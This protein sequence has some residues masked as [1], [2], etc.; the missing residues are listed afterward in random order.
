MY[1]KVRGEAVMSSVPS[2]RTPVEIRVGRFSTGSRPGRP[3]NTS[4]GRMVVNTSSSY[5]V[6]MVVPFP[7]SYTGI[8]VPSGAWVMVPTVS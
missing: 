5:P 3:S 6:E 1:P 8:S 7:R 2:S 4:S